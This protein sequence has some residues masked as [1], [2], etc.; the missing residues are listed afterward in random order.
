MQV[1]IEIVE[2]REKPLGTNNGGKRMFLL[3]NETGKK[4]KKTWNRFILEDL[5][6]V[7]YNTH[8]TMHVLYNPCSAGHYIQGFS[9][10]LITPDDLG[11][12][13]YTIGCL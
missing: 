11:K 2:K 12:R 4:E 7:M 13:L 3:I 1:W 8:V 10:E 9:E 6:G 5:P